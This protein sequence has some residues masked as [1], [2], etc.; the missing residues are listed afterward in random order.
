[1]APIAFADALLAAWNDRWP[2]ARTALSSIP[3]SPQE[4]GDAAVHNALRALI[5]LA[6]ESPKEAIRYAGAAVQF[7]RTH[8]DDPVHVSRN[9]HLGRVL[10]AAAL[11]F[12][13]QSARGARLLL[14]REF[15][16]GA[17]ESVKALA[18]EIDARRIDDL[19]ERA[20]DVYGY[21][22]FLA[23]LRRRL[24]ST[25]GDLHLTRKE[26]EILVL[27]S[28]GVTAGEIARLDGVAR[29]TVMKRQKNAVAK[30]GA[31]NILAAISEA[32]RRGLIA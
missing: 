11:S 6:F 25:E 20:S 18:L 13:G 32:R 26:L 22:L 31:P 28:Q 24:Y 16:D 17:P 23:A 29:D 10:A 19:R 7:S 30:L 12:A 8:V 5:A 21:G 15:R 2:A 9:R 1:A 27:R 14:A 3:V 4:P